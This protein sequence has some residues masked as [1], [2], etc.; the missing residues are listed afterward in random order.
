[1]SLIEYLRRQYP[2]PNIREIY[3]YQQSKT[4]YQRSMNYNEQDLSWNK[5]KSAT[6][7]HK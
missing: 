5:L 3:G 2:S 6:A 7:W 1:M 4:A